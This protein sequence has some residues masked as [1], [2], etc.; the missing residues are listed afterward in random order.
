M[1][2]LLIAALFLLSVVS[3]FAQ[4]YG[5]PKQV[6]A[7]HWMVGT[8]SGTGKIVFG[9]H[10]VEITS[11]M[12][13]SYDGQ[14]LKEVSTDKSATSTLTKTTMTGWDPSKSEYISY[15]FTN[16]APTARIAHGKLN[17]SKL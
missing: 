5:P 7:L 1:K 10:A 6:K 3:V 13:V 17:G 11:T 9:G 4:D 15:S 14:F 2:R 16:A 8:W 12:T